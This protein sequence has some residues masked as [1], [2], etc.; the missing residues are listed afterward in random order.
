VDPVDSSN[1]ILA[2]LPGSVIGHAM[3]DLPPAGAGQPE[4]LTVELKAG[5]PHGLVRIRYRLMRSRRG[6]STNWFWT[7]VHAEP[8]RAA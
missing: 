7:A 5:E 8:A 2:L 1:G 3:K 6:K 4:E